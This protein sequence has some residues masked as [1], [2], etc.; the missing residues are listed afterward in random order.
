MN[1]K[2]YAASHFAGSDARTKQRSEAKHTQLGTRERCS[3]ETVKIFK[4]MRI[5]HEWV[6]CFLCFCLKKF[7]WL[8]NLHQAVIR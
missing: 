1:K 7:P 5:S 8:T 2:Q 4:A 6:V 3:A